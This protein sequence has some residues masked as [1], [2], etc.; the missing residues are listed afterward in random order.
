MLHVFARNVH[1]SRHDFLDVVLLGAD[2]L[3]LLLEIVDDLLGDDGV[4]PL[5]PVDFLE[6]REKREEIKEKSRKS[7]ENQRNQ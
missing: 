2:F 6:M 1:D 4:F 7:I 5:F 3:E